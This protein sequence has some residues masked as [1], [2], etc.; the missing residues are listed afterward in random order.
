MLGELDRSCKEF[1]EDAFGH[2]IWVYRHVARV[3]I[4][5]PCSSMRVQ[6][7]FYLPVFSRLSGPHLEFSCHCFPSLVERREPCRCKSGSADVVRISLGSI[8]Q[9][10]LPARYGL[11]VGERCGEWPASQCHTIPP[12]RGKL[13]QQ[14]LLSS[15]ALPPEPID[16]VLSCAAPLGSLPAF[17]FGDVVG[18]TDA[19]DICSIT[20]QHSLFPRS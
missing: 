7:D 20:E 6:P 9:P 1:R 19:T 10:S 16:Q 13:H 12:L 2:S 4:D 17:A 15:S 3:E 8:C 5:N 18:K 11:V 14:R